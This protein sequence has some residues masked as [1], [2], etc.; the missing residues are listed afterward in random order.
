MRKERKLINKHLRTMR[1]TFSA[2]YDADCREDLR[3]K[4]PETDKT[5]SFLFSF[6]DNFASV[7]TCREINASTFRILG[8]RLEIQVSEAKRFFVDQLLECLLG[9]VVE[10]H[11]DAEWFFSDRLRTRNKKLLIN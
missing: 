5:F 4:H 2:I 6:K 9:Q 3:L 7:M 11:G 8:F 1:K 10:L